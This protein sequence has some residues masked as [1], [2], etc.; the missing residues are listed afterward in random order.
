MNCPN[1]RCN[2]VST[3]PGNKFRNTEITSANGRLSRCFLFL[4]MRSARTI[5]KA[6]KT[7]VWLFLIAVGCSKGSEKFFSNRDTSVELAS[8][9]GFLQTVPGNAILEDG[10]TMGPQENLLYLLVICPYLAAESRGTGTDYGK[11]FNSYISL[12]DTTQGHI[13]VAVR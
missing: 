13:S 9:N 10:R 1:S 7:C 4:A 6:G 2:P 5:Y 3:F 11:R 8:H 12:W